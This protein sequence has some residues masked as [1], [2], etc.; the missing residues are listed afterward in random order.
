[1]KFK[2][3]SREIIMKVDK[4]KKKKNWKN[5]EEIART[6]GKILTNVKIF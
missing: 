1:M 5:R 4:T 6:L 2:E 3:N